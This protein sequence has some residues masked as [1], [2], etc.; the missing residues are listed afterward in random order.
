[1]RETIG[2]LEAEREGLRGKVARL[3]GRLVDIGRES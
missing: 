1:M 2:G 3:Q